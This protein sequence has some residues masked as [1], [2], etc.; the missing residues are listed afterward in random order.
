[1][2][3]LVFKSFRD[4]GV[5]WFKK[6]DANLHDKPKRHVKSGMSKKQIAKMMQHNRSIGYAYR[7]T[8]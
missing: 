7:E 3:K 1:M 5:Y 2:L 4:L 6:D 8:I